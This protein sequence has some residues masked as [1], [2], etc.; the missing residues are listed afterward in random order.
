MDN[1]FM[2]G[3]GHDTFSWEN[4]GN[5]KEG[6]GS[7]GEEM[8]VLVYRLMQFT[9]REALA[10]DFGRDKA[11]YYMQESGHIAGAEFA[12]N[13]LDL[14]VGF[15]DFVAELQ[16][17]LQELKIGI[18]RLE[19]VDTGAEEIILTVGEDL[20]CSGLPISGEAV[21][22]Y[23]EGFIA[24]ILEVYTGKPYS[25]REIDCW[26]NGDRTCRFKCTVMK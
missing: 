6:R 26:A 1:V 22:N 21:C 4:L 20:D 2:Q 23:D 24:G 7:L 14:N 19:S 8:P 12:K 18:L 17:K 5:I 11:D 10:R 13:V 25:V 16:K 3:K 15:D 9:L